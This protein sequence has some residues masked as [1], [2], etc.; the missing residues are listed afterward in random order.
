MS[1]TQGVY[2]GTHGGIQF[3]RS[4]NSQAAFATL[5]KDDVNVSKRRFS[6]DGSDMVITGDKIKITRLTTDGD[7]SDKNLKLVKGAPAQPSIERYAFKDMLGGLR[8][9]DTFKKAVNGD[10]D[11]A[12][13]LEFGSSS[14]KIKVKVDD[15]SDDWLGLAKITDWSFTTQRASVDK[16]ILGDQFVQS[17]EAGLIQGQGTCTAIWD[18]K[19]Q[20]CDDDTGSPLDNNGRG[21]PSDGKPRMPVTEKDEI[22]NYFVQLCMRVTLGAKF[23]GRFFIKYGGDRDERDPNQLA[24]F[25]Q[26]D[27]IVTNV[28]MAFAPDQIVKTRI[29][30]VTEGDFQ[31]RCM[32]DQDLDSLAAGKDG[33]IS[34]Q[35]MFADT[36][37]LATEDGRILVG[38]E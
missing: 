21:F 5:T 25:W 32:D 23:L 15:K 29:Q 26:A 3:R 38:R 33:Q 17:Y 24:V 31:L 20:F 16:T 22:A 28:S 6:F 36:L 30:F 34:R 12:L 27:C 2:L 19:Q 8:L 9:Y 37:E 1:N 18:D 11:E 7:T 13:E 4:R 14:Q 35:A 10:E